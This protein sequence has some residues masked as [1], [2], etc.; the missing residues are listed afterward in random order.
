MYH[1]SLVVQCVYGWSDK[2]G[3]AEGGKEGRELSGGWEKVET[4]WSLVFIYIFY[5]GLTSIC[6]PVVN[7]SIPE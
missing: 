6:V 1:V 4:A 2:G 5:Y 3:E 7:T